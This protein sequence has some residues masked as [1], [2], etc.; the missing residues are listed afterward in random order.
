[1]VAA[2]DNGGDRIVGL[3]AGADGYLVKPF[4]LEDLQ[5]RLRAVLRRSVLVTAAP[6]RPH[7]RRPGTG[8]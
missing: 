2:C 7:R 8:C 5:A 4:V 1:M 6:R 3:D